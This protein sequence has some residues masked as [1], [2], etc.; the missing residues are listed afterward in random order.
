MMELTKEK[1]VCIRTESSN[2]EDFEHVEELTMDVPNH[3]D[4]RCDM[5]HITLFHK[6]LLRL[7]AYRFNDRVCQQFFLVKS[8]DALVKVNAC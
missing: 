5:Y 6:Q 4:G 2:L 3:R 7:G 8:F 1:I